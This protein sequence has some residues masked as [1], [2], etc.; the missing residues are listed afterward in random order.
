MKAITYNKRTTLAIV[1]G[2]AALVYI[3][4]ILFTSCSTIHEGT[5]C[6]CSTS[7]NFV[8]CSGNYEQ[9]THMVKRISY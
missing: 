2:Y 8:G 1:I 5:T 7:K 4:A 3:L 6:P 9:T